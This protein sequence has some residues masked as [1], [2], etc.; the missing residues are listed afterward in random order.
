MTIL[1][2]SLAGAALL[3]VMAAPAHALPVAGFL[4]TN[5]LLGGVFSLTTLTSLGGVALLSGVAI[6]KLRRPK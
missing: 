2:T 1:R 3:L 6:A 5:T 4:F